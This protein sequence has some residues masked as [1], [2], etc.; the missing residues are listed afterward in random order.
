MN[1]KPKRTRTLESEFVSRWLAV[2]GDL[3][4]WLADHVTDR[5]P[6]DVPLPSERRIVAYGVDALSWDDVAESGDED[7]LALLS[8]AL[9]LIDRA[10]VERLIGEAMRAVAAE[11]RKQLSEHWG[12]ET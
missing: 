3:S 2:R 10:E 12:D 5:A 4:S 7:N 1:K 8:A 9:K 6:L 11:V